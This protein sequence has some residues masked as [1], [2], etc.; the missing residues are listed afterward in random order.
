MQ[1][2]S[3]LWKI[4]LALGIAALLVLYAQD[5]G[6][7]DEE[8]QVSPSD[9]DSANPSDPNPSD[10]LENNNS[11][12][13]EAPPSTAD[14]PD[15][16]ALECLDHDGLARHDHVTLQIFIDGNPHTVES[17]IGI[18]TDVCN[19]NENYM[20]TI[21]THD[22][23]GKLH[24]ELNEAGDI[25][26]GVFFDI[27]GYHFNETGIFDHRVNETHEMVMHV[28][29]TNEDATEENRVTTFD[30]Y[31]IQNGEVIEVHYRLKAN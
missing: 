9:E 1:R 3:S 12:A 29:A 4:I 24:V 15:P 13:S 25:S 16:L 11:N 18:Q 28:H 5:R 6:F 14:S 2:E 26:L 30:N 8:E 10:D 23:T 7:F 21:H 22:D 19:G 17:A 20:H 31:L 27:W